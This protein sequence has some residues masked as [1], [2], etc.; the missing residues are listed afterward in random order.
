MVQKSLEPVAKENESQICKQKNRRPKIRI[1]ESS[2]VFPILSFMTFRECCVFGLLLFWLNDPTCFDG[3]FSE[4]RRKVTGK[5]E[6]NAMKYQAIESCIYQ[7]L[8]QPKINL[9][10]DGQL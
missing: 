7:R 10:F 8:S 6:K 2:G 9:D 5:S 3:L 4:F 1:T